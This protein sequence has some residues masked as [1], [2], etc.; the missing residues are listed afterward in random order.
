MIPLPITLALRRHLKI[1]YFSDTNIPSKVGIV[2]VLLTVVQ[3][4]KFLHLILSFSLI[5]FCILL[6]IFLFAKIT[7]LQKLFLQVLLKTCGNT[8]QSVNDL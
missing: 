3:S 8:Y 4:S 7:E 2:V 5:T 1:K 6:A